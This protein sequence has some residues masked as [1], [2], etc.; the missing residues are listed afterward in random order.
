MKKTNA[1]NLLI[2]LALFISGCGYTAKAYYLPSSMKSVYIQTLINK[3]EEPN[4]ENELKTKL[5]AAFQNDGNLAIAANNDAA[6]AHLKG[7][8]VGYTR[9]VMRYTSDESVQEYKL[10]ITVNFEFIDLSSGKPI[11]KADNFSGNACYYLSGANA[12]SETSARAEALDNLS[13]LMLNKIIT[14]W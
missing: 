11:V 1:F 14:L 5:V 3:T 2:C 13:R 9:Q 8:I 7:E 6:D 12:K 10:N 4:L